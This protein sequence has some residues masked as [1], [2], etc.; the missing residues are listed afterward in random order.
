M[1]EKDKRKFLKA[2]TK[3]QTLVQ[4]NFEVVVGFK[5]AN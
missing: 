1:M 5:S 2:K 3:I 4:S